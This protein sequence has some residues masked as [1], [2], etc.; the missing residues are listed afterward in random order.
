MESARR[1]DRWTSGAIRGSGIRS[2]LDAT[3]AVELP[4]RFDAKHITVTPAGDDGLRIRE[5]VD[6]DFGSTERHGYQRVVPNDFGPPTDVTATSPDAP[7]SL[8]V[9][10]L[11][12]DETQIRI[13]DPAVIV[14]GQHR[15]TLSYT[16]RDA[17]LSDG[18]LA[19]DIIGTGDTLETGQL[20]IIVTGL[21]L[22][23]PV[24]NVGTAGAVGGCTLSR[25]GG[26]YR[27][28]ISPL[29]PGE[30]VTISGTITAR[31]DPVDVPEPTL[32][33]RR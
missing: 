3:N 12:T 22:Q 6:Q 16:L 19:L 31:T 13:G 5:V 9:T 4:E 33:P 28:V 8:S 17:H 29:L 30:G 11:D 21:D 24:C 7:A 1:R 25:D 10:P 15:Y 2:P 26:L 23:D 32:P 20:E 18:T 14:T 27:A